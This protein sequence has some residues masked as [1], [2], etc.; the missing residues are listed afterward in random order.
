[1]ELSE[2]SD[3]YLVS[4]NKTFIKY[5]EKYDFVREID[6]GDRQNSLIAWKLLSDLKS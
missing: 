3:M 6:L 1:M 5:I 2:L 4:K